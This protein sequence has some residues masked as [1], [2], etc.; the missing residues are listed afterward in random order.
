MRPQLCGAGAQNLPRTNSP[1]EVLVPV[2]L[3][4]VFQATRPSKDAG[5]GVGA[6]RP[7]LGEEV[8]GR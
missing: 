8:T 3:A 5:D 6:S 1:D 7:A 2:Q 4:P